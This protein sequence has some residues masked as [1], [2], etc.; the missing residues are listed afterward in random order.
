MLSHMALTERDLLTIQAAYPN[1]R[2]ELRDGK[3]IVMSPSDYMS[4]AIV[5]R[6][7]RRLLDWVEPRKLGFVVTSS[8]GFRLPNG[9]VLAPDVS[10]VAKERMRIPPR[11]YADVVPNLVVE[12]K[13]PSDRV[14]ELGEKLSLIRSFGAQAALLIDPDERTVKVD[15]D[16]QPPRTLTDADMLDLPGLLPG[17]S[18]PVSELWPQQLPPSDVQPPENPNANNPDALEADLDPEGDEPEGY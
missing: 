4:E 3:I 13:S 18:M 16:D 14:A 1:S 9:D 10:F 6:L 15:T 8:A 12:V 5:A 2:L 7:T 11:D 17:W